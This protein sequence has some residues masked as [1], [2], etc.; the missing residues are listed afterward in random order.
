MFAVFPDLQNPLRIRALG[1]KPFWRAVYLPEETFECSFTSMHRLLT[2]DL[3]KSETTYIPKSGGATLEVLCSQICFC[4]WIHM[5]FEHYNSI[6]GQWLDTCQPAAGRAGH[7]PFLNVQRTEG[8][9]P[10]FQTLCSRM[11]GLSVSIETEGPRSP[12][13]GWT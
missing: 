7:Q 5:A 3:E 4:M 13:R 11:G 10:L 9:S 2:E 1:G 12:R 6:P 8:P